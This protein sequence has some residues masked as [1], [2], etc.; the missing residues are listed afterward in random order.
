MSRLFFDHLIVF[1]KV[2]M[3]IRNTAKNPEEKEE[4]WGIIDKLVH[5]HVL[6]QILDKLPDENHNDF[7]E[8]YHAR[9]FDEDL[10]NFLNE[11]VEEN[12]EDIIRE[13][14]VHLEKDIL[15]EVGE[16]E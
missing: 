14:I 15:R 8:K 4:L 3:V 16:T 11:K 5:S 10:I 6:I 12:I 1:E 13:A 2:D 9:P 7:L